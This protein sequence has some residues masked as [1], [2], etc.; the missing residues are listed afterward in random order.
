MEFTQEQ[1][2]NGETMQKTKEEVPVIMDGAEL[3][4]NQLE[5]V[6]GGKGGIIEGGCILVNYPGIPT[7]TSSDTDLVLY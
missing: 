5:T 3:S 1:K 6:A 4:D 7:P 2:M